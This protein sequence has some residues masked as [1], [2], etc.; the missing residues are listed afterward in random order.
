M[1]SL[2]DNEVINHTV[3]IYSLHI[4]VPEKLPLFSVPLVSPA[5]YP[6]A[7]ANVLYVDIV[8]RT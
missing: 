2:E 6:E 8:Y 4:H 5:L 7:E 3:V 1:R